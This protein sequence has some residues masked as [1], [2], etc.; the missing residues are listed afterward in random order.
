MFRMVKELA[1]KLTYASFLVVA[2]LLVDVPPTSATTSE[3]IGG[4]GGRAFTLKCP[5]NMVLVGFRAQ[6]GAWVDGAG[7][8]CTP[9][10]GQG[11]I[12]GSRSE[13][14]RAGGNG[15]SPQEAYCP[16]G[17]GATGLTLTFTRGGGKPRE[18]VNSIGIA[19]QHQATASAC[20]STGEGCGPIPPKQR[21]TLAVQTV[22]EYKYNIM[23]CPSDEYMTGVQGRSGNA[24][25]ALGIICDS[26]KP[27]PVRAIGRK[28]N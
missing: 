2:C 19:C 3:V 14:G 16:N 24:I 18:F 26:V 23:F 7:I 10:N 27:R 20:I 6:A 25:D 15:G 9:V 17:Q 8:L 5:S 11:Q 22:K 12:S 21:Y 1:M 13:H 28:R 4:P